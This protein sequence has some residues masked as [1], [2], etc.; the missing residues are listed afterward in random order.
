MPS[1]VRSR[2]M[3]N[4]DA[5]ATFAAFSVAFIVSHSDIDSDIG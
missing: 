1:V 4:R 5:V 3:V 2:G